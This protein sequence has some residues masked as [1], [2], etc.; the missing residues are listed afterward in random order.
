MER[1]FKRDPITGQ[2]FIIGP[3]RGCIFD[4]AFSEIAN[5]LS[6]L[7]GFRGRAAGEFAEQSLHSFG[8]SAGLEYGSKKFYVCDVHIFLQRND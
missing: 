2:T 7:V 8:I 6:K 3:G 1:D 5:K 4:G